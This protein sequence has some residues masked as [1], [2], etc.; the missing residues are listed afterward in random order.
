MKYKMGKFGLWG[1]ILLSV[2]FL[3]VCL[4]VPAQAAEPGKTV[5][6][7]WYADTS[8]TGSQGERSGYSYEYEQMVAAYTGWTYEYVKADWNELLQMVQDGDIDL[9]SNISYTDDRAQK[10]LFSD[11]PMGEEKYYIY[12]DLT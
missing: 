1:R 12:A 9:L 6:I 3:L 5:R 2:L 8:S 11:L 10:M 4:L 7:G